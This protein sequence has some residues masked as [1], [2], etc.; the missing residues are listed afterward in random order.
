MSLQRVILHVLRSFATKNRHPKINLKKKVPHVS[1]LALINSHLQLFPAAPCILLRLLQANQI[2]WRSAVK[3]NEQMK[4]RRQR[5]QLAIALIKFS[6]TTWQQTK[7][8]NECGRT[9]TK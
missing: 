1:N 9:T 2:T 8:V 6:G 5:V 7:A 4:P 3:K